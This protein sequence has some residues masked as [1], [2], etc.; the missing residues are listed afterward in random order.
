MP[1]LTRTAAALAAAAFAFA[2]AAPAAQATPAAPTAPDPVSK[3]IVLLKPGATA[4]AAATADRQ[5]EP[6]GGRATTVFS[7][8]VKGYATSLTASQ[9]AA[10][11][12]DSRVQ[13]V[14][15]DQIVHIAATEP[16]APWGLDRIDQRT[17]PVSGSYDYGTTGSGVKAYVIDTGIRATHADFGGRASTGTDTIDGGAADDCNGHGTHVAGT[18]GGTTY[19]VAKQ[20]SLIAVRV[21]D[22]QG[23]GATSGIISGI[24]WVVANHQAGQPAVAN[25]SL[26][27]AANA[28]LD[29]AIQSMVND[30]I[31]VSVAAGN[32]TQDA[33]KV[34][35]AR[36]ASAITVGASDAND[37]AATF[38][39]WGTCV[40]LFAPGVNVLSSSNGSDTATATLSGTSMASPHVAGA[41]ARYL[42]SNPGATPAQVE[43]ALK[44]NST[45]DI[46]TGT[47]GGGSKSILCSLLGQGCPP[48]PTANNDL[49][50]V[51]P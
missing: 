4:D 41:A 29:A 17:R 44:A 38:S 46:V 26:G 10:L 32:E 3:V 1:R 6:L 13:G 9:A 33:C 40:D 14:Y 48:G 2:L 51:A 36:T 24:D 49:L 11:R 16:G 27:G 22:C 12:S 23:S 19:G 34:S 20:A 15:P 21:L 42:Q 37:A 18:I 7:K 39:N 8:A 31:S 25:L 47:S 30:G 28:P 50:Y 43:S 5:L 35:P 45:K